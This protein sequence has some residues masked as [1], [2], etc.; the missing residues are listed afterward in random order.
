LRQF[1]NVGEPGA[2]RILLLCGVATGLPL[3]SNGLRVLNRLGWGRIQKNYAATYRS[4]QDE[5]KLE[6]P[7]HVERLKEAHLLLRIHGKTLC[8][9][10]MPLCHQCPVAK[11]CRYL[12]STKVSLST[13][14]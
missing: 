11:E 12:Q 13:P 2:E 14:V 9:E 4:V 6:V 7:V 5:L 3:E 10:R 1:P 8:K